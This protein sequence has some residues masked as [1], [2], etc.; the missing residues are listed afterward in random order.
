MTI[1]HLSDTHGKHHLLKKMPKADIIVH[2]G[3]MS[4]DGTDSEILDFLNWFCDLDFQHKIFIVGNHD[5]CLE[6]MQIKGLPKIVSIY[7]TRA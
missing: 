1:L 3:D 4:E 6:G 5:L 7:V 2:S